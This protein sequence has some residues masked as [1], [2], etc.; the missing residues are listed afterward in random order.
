MARYFVLGMSVTEFRT[1]KK[2]PS[3]HTHFGKDNLFRELWAISACLMLSEKQSFTYS[4]F[5]DIFGPDWKVG[6]E[7]QDSGDIVPI[8]APRYVDLFFRR[9][10]TPMM[11]K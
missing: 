3:F 11:A 8:G 1:T 4:N 5:H 7:N 2:Q 6:L 10:P 9:L